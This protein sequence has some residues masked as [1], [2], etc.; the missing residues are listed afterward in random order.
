MVA[1]KM[2]FNAKMDSNKRSLAEEGWV[3]AYLW[4]A[5]IP[6]QQGKT[7]SRA[8]GRV[9][10]HLEPVHRAGV[11]SAEVCGSNQLPSLPDGRLW[12]P[13]ADLP[14]EFH[15]PPLPRW[16]TCASVTFTAFFLTACLSCTSHDI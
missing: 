13:P 15:L 5:Q 1:R 16:R 14:G 8:A 6:P 4:Y 2:Q 11:A 3:F 9:G 10:T 12:W 7:E